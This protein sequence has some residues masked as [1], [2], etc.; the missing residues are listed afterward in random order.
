MAVA[1]NQPASPALPSEKMLV[2]AKLRPNVSPEAAVRVLADMVGLSVVA[3]DNLYY[4]TTP[5]KVLA[6]R[7][8]MLDKG[9]PTEVPK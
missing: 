5:E 6:L 8:D 9:R 1:V 2:T 4:V 7:G 3:K